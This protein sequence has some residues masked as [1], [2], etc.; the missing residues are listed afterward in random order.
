MTSSA[1]VRRGLL[2]AVATG[3]LAFASLPSVAQQSEQSATKPAAAPAAPAK[4]EQPAPGT[5]LYG[6][7]DYAGAKKLAPV[8]GPPL[9]TAADKL[10]V[11]KL[12]VPKGFHIE[13]YASG[14]AGARTIRESDKGTVYVG[15]WQIGK[16]YAVTPGAH[17][18]K[19]LYSGLD[20]PNGIVVHN[21]TLYIAEHQKVSKA[22]KIEENLDHPPKLA[23]VYGDLPAPRPHG[24]RFMGLG[25]D[26]KLYIGIGQPC[27]DCLP[28]PTNGQIRRINLDGSDPQVYVR[29]VR[30]TVGFDWNPANKQLYFTDN[31][32]DWLGEDIPQD[33]LNR[34]TKMGEHFGSPFCYQGNILDSDYG[35]GHSCKDYTPPVALMGPH[36]AALGMRFYTGRM[37]PAKYRNAIFVARHGSWNRTHKFGGDVALVRLNRDGTVRSVEPFLTGFLV[38]N[39]YIG[40]PVDVQ[41]LHDGSLLV[42]D[43]WNGAIYRVTYGKAHTASR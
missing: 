37:F 23:Q 2:L 28:P 38:N 15:T 25:P 33:E 40:R 18:V 43:D 30:N 22:E 4:E 17:E 19:T 42:S 36:A 21:D 35:W 1:L 39:N 10:P 20:W 7:P 5:P 27:N 13:V 41:P 6:R 26:N 8:A 9:A 32:R 14:L 16:V 11:A 24:W 29:G 3:A 12:K 34:I 31:G